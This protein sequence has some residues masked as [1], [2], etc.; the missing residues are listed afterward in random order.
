MNLNTMC[1]FAAAVFKDVVHT[2]G[3]PPFKMVEVT[4][5]RSR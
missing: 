5:R 2:R 3:G 1:R 4:S